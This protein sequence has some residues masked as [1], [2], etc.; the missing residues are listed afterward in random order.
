MATGIY[1][2]KF[3]G[4]DKVY[5][6]QSTNLSLRLTQHKSLFKSNKA[7]KKMQEAYLLYGFPRMEVLTYCEEHE[8]DDLEYEAISLYDSVNNGFNTRK[9]PGGGSN[10]WGD[11]NGRSKYKNTQIIDSFFLLLQTPKLTYLEIYA[12][13]GVPKGTLVDISNGTGHTWLKDMFP[14]EYTL[15][16]SYR[17]KRNTRT[18]SKILSPAGEVYTVEHLSNFC[19]K[20]GLD[21]GNMSK[22]LTG[23][24]KQYL[25]W[26]P[27]PSEK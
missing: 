1:I 3:D 4:T 21:V 17:H 15:L 18:Y 2:L 22:V 9:S 19:I 7:S 24:K 23:K 25:G 16:L 5:I 6:G 8:L 26:V 14:D 11:S 10:L 13:T 27:I 20:H 12:K